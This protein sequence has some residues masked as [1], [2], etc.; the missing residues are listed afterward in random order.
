MPKKKRKPITAEDLYRFELIT[1]FR[2]S[3]DGKNV[4][5]SLQRVDK[6]TEKKFSNLWLVPTS[7]GAPKQFTHG[8]HSDTS[9]RW[10]PDGSEIA[11]ISN[12]DDER[13]PQIYVIPLNG[14]EARKLTDLKGTVL[15]FR[16]APDGKSL[17]LMFRKKDKE[18]VEREKDEQKKKLGVVA[19]VYERPFYKLDG[20]GFKP[21]ERIHIWI[22]NARTGKAKQLTDSEVFDEVDPVFSPDGKQILFYSNRSK[23]PDITIYEGEFYLMPAGGGRLKKVPTYHGEKFL[24]SFSPDGKRVAFFG[25]EGEGQWWR[26]LR[27]WIAP[28]K[29]KGKAKCLTDDYDFTV[30]CDTINDVI[31]AL[32]TMHPVWSNDG[33]S[34]YFQAS[35]H[36]NTVLKKIDIDTLEVEDVVSGDGAVGN[37]CFDD[38]REKL[39]YYHAGMESIGQIFV[40]ELSNR[41]G[42]KGTKRKK[43]GDRQLTKVNENILGRIDLGE[44]EE[45]WFKGADGN[46]LQ[47]WIIRPPGFSPKR[48]YPSILEIHGGPWVQYGN[49][50]MHEFFY[51]ASKG[52]V[53]CFCNPRG[54]QGYGEEHAKAIDNSW[55]D[56]DFADL[57][58]FA[59]FIAR[60]RYIDKD[61]M[62]VTGGSYGGY[63]T[64][65][66]IGRTDRFRAAVTQRSVSNY[67][68]MWGSSD[69]NWTFQEALANKPPWEDL[70]NYWKQSPMK[71]IGGAKT[72]TM[73][74]H[75]EMD[76]RCEIE[77]GEQVFVALKTLGVDTEMVRFPDE[78][79]GLSRGG[80]TDRRIA[81]LNHML[82]WFDKYLKRRAKKKGD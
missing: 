55:G 40:K 2:I 68:S 20:M 72:P 62:G 6:K 18:A 45:F 54:G 27:L 34:I 58:K 65:M 36:G 4:I 35:W 64:N 69:Y 23:E 39:C 8:D 74:I 76:Q 70:E 81:R 29:G 44:V 17:V 75:S 42:T 33:K 82:R 48:K 31:G 71:Y 37:F 80:R 25:N 16:W 28:T 53:V 47:G 52:Y 3:P 46:D 78:P 79:H 13:Q 1:D 41:E 38:N 60:K 12:R 10:S 77:Q 59:D 15:T 7:R 67:I 57:M 73:V 9:P 61:R 30:G 14:G 63:M 22:V 24:P 56:R 49:L 32:D 43:K 26:N 66:I 19:R 21:K 11:F 50:F 5:Y 51:L